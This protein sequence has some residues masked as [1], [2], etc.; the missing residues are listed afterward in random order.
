MPYAFE[1]GA[2]GRLA[3]RLTGRR[4]LRGCG[5]ALL[6]VK[7]ILNRGLA[8]RRRRRRRTLGWL[9]GAGFRS[10]DP[11]PCDI[12]RREED[13]RQNRR[14]GQAPHDRIQARR[15]RPHQR[16]AHQVRAR[17]G[18]SLRR[19]M[20]PRRRPPRHSRLRRRRDAHNRGN[21]PSAHR[22]PETPQSNPR[23]RRH[24]HPRPAH[25]GQPFIAPTR[26]IEALYEKCGLGEEAT[27]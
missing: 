9:A 4:R 3:A 6:D 18:P 24:R 14:D 22:R 26:P 19:R 2:N 11:E 17:L 25:G 23:K 7:E 8:D 21:P 13:Q 5:R 10:L 20:A 1:R 12:E 15:P 16:A 27:L